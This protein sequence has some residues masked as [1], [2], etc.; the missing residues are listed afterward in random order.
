[1]INNLKKIKHAYNLGNCLLS[2]PY[3][4]KGKEKSINEVNK[5]PLRF[6]AINY[7]LEDLNKETKYLEIGVRNPKDNFDKIKSENKISVDPVIENFENPVDFKMTSDEFFSQL[8]RGNILN[9]HVKFDVVFIDG[10]HLADQ[11]ERDIINSFKILNEKGFIVLHD[12]NPPTEFHASESYLYRMSPSKGFWN[13]TTWKAFFKFRQK[14]DYYSC[15][16]DSDWGIGIISKKVNLG[17]P[18]CVKNPYFEYK[19]FDKNRK[20][21]LNLVSFE[22]FKSKL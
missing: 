15:C 18:T 5:R 14:K 19:I 17:N 20:G 22:E 16:I 12:C 8:D 2:D 4:I 6:D 11:V 3:H 1:M 7:I 10:L 21:S 9:K 13:G